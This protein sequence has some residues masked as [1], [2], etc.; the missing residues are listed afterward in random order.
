M[1]LIE[2]YSM[3]YLRSR[4]SIILFPRLC[5]A[6]YLILHFYLFLQPSGFHILA[7]FVMFLFMVAS[8][9]FCVRAYELKAYTR[10]H[11]SID[12]PR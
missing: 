1:M 4:S 8:M 11:V 12:Q 2:Y 3:I 5:F 10:G 7:I 9:V 6:S